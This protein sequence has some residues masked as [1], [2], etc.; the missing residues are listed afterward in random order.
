MRLYTTDRGV[1]REDRP[2]TLSILGLPVADVGALL[3]GSGTEA[4]R[5]AAARETVGLGE[6]V[7]GPPVPRPGKVIIVGLNYP[8]HGEEAREA[9]EAMGRGDVAFPTEPVFRF[10]AGSAITAHGQ[11]ITPPALAPDRLDYEGEI[12]VVI[13]RAARDVPRD[14]AW[15]HIA[16]LTIVNDVTARDVQMRAVNGDP[17]VSDGSAKSFDTFKPLGPCLVTADEFP[18][19]LDLRL[20]TRVNGELRQDDRTSTL[21]HPFEDLVA[22]LSRFHT[23]EAGDVICTGTPRGVGYF[24]DRFLAPGDT[25]EITVDG[26]GTLANTVSA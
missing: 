15:E 26:I 13:G 14:Q 2:G 5:H 22:H 8:S 18:R 9:L 4:A 11:P 19:P 20:Q 24:A 23:L 1:G 7:L 25:V 17:A 10:V 12:A 6:V 16:G 21:L 3:Q